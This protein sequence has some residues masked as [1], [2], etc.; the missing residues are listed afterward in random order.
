MFA[1]ILK[2]V[3]HNAVRSKWGDHHTRDKA[4]K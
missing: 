4:N 1:V 2:E 3:K